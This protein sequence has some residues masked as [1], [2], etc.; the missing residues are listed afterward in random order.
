MSAM[1]EMFIC[2]G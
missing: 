2:E 1:F